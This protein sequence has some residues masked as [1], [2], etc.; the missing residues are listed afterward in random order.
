MTNHSLMPGSVNTAISMRHVSGLTRSAQCCLRFGLTPC[1]EHFQPDCT[2][3]PVCFGRGT[4]LRFTVSGAASRRFVSVIPLKPQWPLIQ[5]ALQGFLVV[6]TVT[7]DR[8]RHRFL[9][10]QGMTFG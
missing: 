10:V 9:L 5:E 2:V 1:L 7:A 4:A 6:R 8:L 3:D